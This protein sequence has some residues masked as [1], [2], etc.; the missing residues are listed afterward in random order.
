MRKIALD[1]PVPDDMTNR[2]YWLRTEILEWADESE[3]EV[4]ALCEQ[5]ERLIP[6]LDAISGYAYVLESMLRK[7]EAELP[8]RPSALPK[9]FLGTGDG[10]D[11]RPGA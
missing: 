8:P 7:R 6:D 11:K 9:P 5:A 1:L 2:E 4:E 3:A 10:D